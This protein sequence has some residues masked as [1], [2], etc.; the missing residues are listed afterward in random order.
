MKLSEIIKNNNELKVQL[1]SKPEYKVALLSNTIINQIAPLLEYEVRT[2]GINLGCTFG[3]YDNIL[4][5]SS[6]FNSYDVVVIFWELANLVDGFQ[7]KANLLTEEELKD[8]LTRF[9]SE[10]DY[11]FQQLQTAPLVLFN[12][13][14]SV[15]FNHGYISKNNFGGGNFF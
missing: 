11:V 5:D 10:I 1:Q 12:T 13:F 8:Y 9:K 6:K 7:Y 2:N 15:V 14:S 4:Q 3:D